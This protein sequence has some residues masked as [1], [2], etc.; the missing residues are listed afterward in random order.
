MLLL[1]FLIHPVLCG[2]DTIFNDYGP[3]MT[4]G[5]G[6]S[7]VSGPSTPN[8]GPLNVRWVASPFT[9]NGNFVL[10][11]IDL[12][13]QA[14]SGTNGAIVQLVN[15]QSGLPGTTVLESWVS[16]SLP[17]YPSGNLALISTGT[18]LHSGTQYWIIAKPFAD[19]TLYVW[20][21]EPTGLAG[22]LTRTCFGPPNND[23]SNNNGCIGSSP[24]WTPSALE[25]FD[26]LGTPVAT[27]ELSS[28]PLLG[29]GL[30][31]VAGAARRKWLRQ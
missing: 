16:N 8:C 4:F 10:T 28:L 17:A 26:V 19:D 12:A 22:L 13:V 29:I 14:F 2:A 5:S 11:Q 20:R 1:V 23:P 30:L 7:C 3:G 25:A 21:P 9:P 18:A 27:S 6:A 24:T 15:D 31:G